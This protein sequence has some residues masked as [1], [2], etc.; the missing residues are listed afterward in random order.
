[1]GTPDKLRAL[2]MNLRALAAVSAAFVCLVG[3]VRTGSLAVTAVCAAEES[4]DAVIARGVALRK[5]GDDQAARD[6]F[7]KVYERSHTARAAGQLGLAEQALGRWEEAESHLREALRSPNDPWVKKNHDALSRDMLLIKGHIARVEIVGEPEGAEVLIN[8]RTVGKLPLSGPISTS[9]GSVDVEARAPGYQHEMRT[10]TLTG[11]QYQRLVMRL[12]K[13]EPARTAMATPVPPAS[14]VTPPT[15]TPSPAVAP[16]PAAKPS[17]DEQP[18]PIRP[19]AK[20]TALGL[21]GAGL[22]VG[23]TSTV[24]RSSKL[25]S[26]KSAN[27]GGCVEMGGR[28]V[29]ADG[30]PVPACQG[31]LDSYKSM[32][33]WQIV[34]FVSAGV[35]AATWLALFLTEPSGAAEPHGGVA[36][37]HS[38]VCAPTADP[39]GAGATCLFTM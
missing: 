25:D 15:E 8:G 33:T 24:V 1:M 23:I 19:I 31:F 29:D 7:M 22:A 27:G 39:T 10:L 17:A 12:Q 18:G 35:F 6:L 11:G 3:T 14:V 34:G 30:N 37:A 13:D 5:E 21:A 20:W 26:F 38:F 32:R 36:R 16:A 9:A 28:A 4:D 2:F